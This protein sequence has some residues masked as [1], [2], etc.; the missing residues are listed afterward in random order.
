MRYIFGSDMMVCDLASTGNAGRMR[1]NI[2][3]ALKPL[4]KEE[5]AF[6]ETGERSLRTK[7]FSPKHQTALEGFPS[8][9]VHID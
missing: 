1:Q 9:A 5:I 3:A 8:G 2:Q 7:A 6:L 4:S